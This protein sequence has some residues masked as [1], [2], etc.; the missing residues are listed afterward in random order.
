[1]IREEFNLLLMRAYNEG[2]ERATKAVAKRR[3]K[4][5][6]GSPLRAACV[7]RLGAVEQAEPDRGARVSK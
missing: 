6:F 7:D 5:S 4:E 2:R 1:M 3:R